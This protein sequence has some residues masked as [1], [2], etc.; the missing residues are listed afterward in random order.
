V[1]NSQA[2][3][4]LQFGLCFDIRDQQWQMLQHQNSI[5][6][7]YLN[8]KKGNCISATICVVSPKLLLCHIAMQAG[9]LCGRH[10]AKQSGNWDGPTDIC[11]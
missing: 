7:V 3:P 6:D 11:R 2:T 1:G 10:L 5:N 9:E 8:L 4:T